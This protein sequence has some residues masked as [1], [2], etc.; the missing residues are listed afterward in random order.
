MGIP[1]IVWNTVTKAEEGELSVKMGLE[2]LKSDEEKNT[3][4][5]AS[6]EN[7]SRLQCEVQI[8]QLILKMEGV[9][10]IVPKGRRFY[11]PFVLALD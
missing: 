5:G 7:E 8:N 3:E 2:S 11:I 1:G 4:W 10:L 9:L 6:V